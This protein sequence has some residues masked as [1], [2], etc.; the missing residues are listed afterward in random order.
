M[1]DLL[2]SGHH[3]GHGFSS[4]YGRG[5]DHHDMGGFDLSARINHFHQSRPLE[6]KMPEEAESEKP[7]IL[8]LDSLNTSV[9]STNMQCLRQY[10]EMEYI[11]KKLKND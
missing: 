7:F 2:D 10:I 1:K 5:L 6:P 9:N 11:D 8:Y 3:L 4:S